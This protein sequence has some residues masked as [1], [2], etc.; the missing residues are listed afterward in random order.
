MLEDS[1]NF[2]EAINLAHLHGLEKNKN[3]LILGLGVNYPNG[4]D[5][6]TKSL[7]AKYP[8]RVLDVPVSEAAFTGMSVGMATMGLNPIVHHGRIEFALLAMDSILTQASKWNFMFGG[9]YPCSLGL[10]INL[11]RQWGNG[12]Q[13]TAAY[14]PLFINTPGIDVLW[15]SNPQEL[16]YQYCWM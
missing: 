9:D 3:S 2:V 14:T 13:H 6:T 11:G 16:A 1:I 7:A 10:R 4:A 5:G 12:P 8:S 15:P